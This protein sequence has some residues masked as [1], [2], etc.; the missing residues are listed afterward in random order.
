MSYFIIKRELHGLLSYSLQDEKPNFSNPAQ[1]NK[2]LR[3]CSLVMELTQRGDCA[4][5]T[6]L[7]A[8]AQTGKLMGAG[9]IKRVV[10]WPVAD[11]EALNTQ[12]VI[13][14]TARMRYAQAAQV[15][16]SQQVRDYLAVQDKLGPGPWSL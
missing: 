8:L 2:A 6:L 3:D 14:E 4:S 7:K 1:D 12:T 9:Y 13:E 5:L 16:G 11:A 15:E 10:N